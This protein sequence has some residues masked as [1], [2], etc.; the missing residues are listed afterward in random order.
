MSDRSTDEIVI[1]VPLVRRLI[2]AQFPQWAHLPIKPVKFG[3]WD[4]RTFH[5]GPEMTVR[6]PSSPAYQLQVEKEQRWLPKLAPQLPLPIP[7][8]L[9]KDEPTAEYPLPWS[10]YRWIE[11]DTA[12]NSRIDDMVQ[13]A[14]DLAAFLNAL[15]NVDA[16]DGPGWGAHNFHRGGPVSH[17]DDQTR[18]AL[19]ALKGRI[20]TSTAREV[21]ETALASEWQRPPVWFH[22]DIATGNLLVRDGSLSAVIDFGTSGTGDPA[23]DLAIAWVSL[24]GDAREAFRAALPLD[25]GT[26]ARGQAWTLWKALIVAAEMPGTDKR[27]AERSRQVIDEVLADHRAFG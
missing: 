6:L 24:A 20:E 21:W 3:G 7:V 17:Y 16:A 14:T 10:I 2:D 19:E 25:K 26:W 15:Q 5:L 27:E 1:G 13:F 22:G 4:N 23:C 12:L 9:A 18:S 8:P 11:G